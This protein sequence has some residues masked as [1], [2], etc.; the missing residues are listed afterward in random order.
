MDGGQQRGVGA[1][2]Q[3]TLLRQERVV[4]AAAAATQRS[5]ASIAV[6]RSVAARR[7]ASGSA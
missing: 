7:T 1:H 4:G 5:E 3:G 2:E 6:A